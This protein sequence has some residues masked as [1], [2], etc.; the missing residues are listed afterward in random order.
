[1]MTKKDGEAPIVWQP[2]DADRKQSR[3]AKFAED[4]N[5]RR[6]LN[7]P[8]EFEEIW[9][10]SVKDRAEFWN[11]IWDFFGVVG[12]KGESGKCKVDHANAMPGARF[13]ADGTLNF[14]EN[15]LRNA[16]SRP[17]LIARNERG[18]RTVVTRRQLLLQTRRFAGWLQ[19]NGA[20]AGDSVCA[21]MPN[22]C[23]TVAAFLGASAIGAVFSSCSMDF[24]ADGASERFA[25]TSPKFLI[26]ADGYLYNGK[27]ISRLPEVNALADR[28]PSLQ[29]IVMVPYLNSSFELPANA[30]LWQDVQ[31]ADQTI[32]E[33]KQT[34]FNAP[35]VALFS[36]GTTGAPKCIVHSAGG[37][38][39]QHLK[40]LG[41]HMNIDQ[42][43]AAFYFTTCGWM[44]WNW[45]I[46]SL[47]LEATVVL[48]EGHPMHP[49]A[50][51][52]W[53]LAQEE[54]VWLFGASAKYF[55]AMRKHEL[56]PSRT[57]SLPH[58]NTICSTGSPL[59]DDGFDY[60]RENISPTIHLASISGGTDLVSCFA[61]GNPLSPVR[62]G[63]LQGRGLGMAVS[64]YDEN[65]C[66]VIDE[67][68]EL[69]CT[70]PFPVM[71][72]EFRQDPG[73]KKYHEAYFA[74]YPGVWRHGDWATLSSA[75][76]MRI[77]GR[78]DATL[79]PGGVRIGTAEIYRPVEALEQVMEA[80]AVGQ[81]WEGDTR[82]VLFIRLQ[83]GIQLDDS[84]QDQMR[85]AIRKSASPRHVPSKIVQVADLPRTRSGKITEIAVRETIHNRP[86]KNINALA[87]P[88]SLEFFRN[89]PE[90]QN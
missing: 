22:I 86:I 27:Q 32:D 79:N 68:G 57:H 54:K 30:V 14:A 55:D 84:L 23:E 18:E 31:D 75:G 1:M 76:G 59:S 7:L 47:A 82:I 10:W 43:R 37:V 71:P 39:L 4:V 48:Y 6:G 64:V 83:P 53:N 16:D 15:L 63:E 81:E 72:L 49:A 24:G 3:M 11:E 73:G 28:L 44:M 51:T 67:P 2:S 74:H 41:L 29:K 58:L 46:S 85:S 88:E 40:E 60:I 52:L 62:R 66:E 42:G 77:H 69:V 38:L 89:L 12:D 9:R 45:L 20:Q 50:D 17:A 80:L 13:F 90:L 33:F 36:S 35:L 21:Y 61:L 87:N 19:A 25:Q 65:G 70:A 26:A 5:A 78:S 56:Q 8:L 34:D